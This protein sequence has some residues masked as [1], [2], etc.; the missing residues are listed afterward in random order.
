MRVDAEN[1]K[2]NENYE[3]YVALDADE[4]SKKLQEKELAKNKKKA[5]SGAVTLA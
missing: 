4:E 5:V 2:I 3:N 1:E